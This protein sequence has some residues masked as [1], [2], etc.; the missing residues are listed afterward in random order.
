[1]PNG[2]EAVPAPAAGYGGGISRWSSLTFAAPQRKMT[3]IYVNIAF[4][5]QK[6]VRINPDFSGPANGPQ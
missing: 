1:L 2:D 6:M 4:Q 5:R 3:F